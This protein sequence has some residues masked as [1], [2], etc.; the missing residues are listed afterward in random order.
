M[1]VDRPRVL[2]GRQENGRSF[3]FDT[4]ELGDVEPELQ[5]FTVDARGPHK[6]FSLLI[7]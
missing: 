2:L 1:M 4:V 3:S 6:R 5:Q 7:R